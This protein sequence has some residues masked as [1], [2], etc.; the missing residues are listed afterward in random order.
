MKIIDIKYDT[1]AF[2]LGGFYFL[3]FASVGA[4]IPYWSL[5][6]QHIGFDAMQIGVLFA[7]MALTRVVIPNLWGQ[8]ADRSGQALRIVQWSALATC[9][10]FM[11]LW[12][13]DQFWWV[14]WVTVLFSALWAAFMPWSR[15]SSRPWSWSWWWLVHSRSR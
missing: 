10:S 8:W 12:V 3:Y 2:R 7:C 5:Y 11:L 1:A 13:S 4:F 9:I 15:W 14:L 6:L